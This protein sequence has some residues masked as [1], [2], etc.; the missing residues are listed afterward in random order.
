[1]RNLT[2]LALAGAALALS[3]GVA[4]AAAPPLVNPVTVPVGTSVHVTPID[5]NSVP[6]VPASQCTLKTTTNAP[7]TNVSVAYDPAGVMLTGLQS[8]A[9]Q[10][11]LSCAN[12]TATV[13]SLAFSITVPWDV[14]AVGTTSP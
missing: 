12:G 13:N 5:Q 10:A 14:T 3:L 9:V 8:G 1:M 2:L 7:F 11:Y 4:Q 6:I